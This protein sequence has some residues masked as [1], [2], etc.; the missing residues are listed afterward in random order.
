MSENLSPGQRVARFAHRARWRLLLTFSPE[1]HRVY[2]SEEARE[3]ALSKNG[4]ASP[5][6][7]ITTPGPG[8]E[9]IY[10]V[11]VEGKTY[12]MPKFVPDS[13]LIPIYGEI[14]DP[15]HPHY[16]EYKEC[17]ISPGDVV[18][19]AGASEGFFTRFA[20][21]KGANVII[22]EP[23]QVWIDALHQTFAPEIAA[24]RIHIE[25]ACLE[26]HVG[27]AEMNIDPEIG[28][29][30]DDQPGK[31]ELIPLLTLDAL[32]A[33]SK[34]GRCDFIKMDIEGAERRAIAGAQETLRKYKPN[35]SIAVYHDPSGYLDIRSDLNR[36]HP[37]YQVTAKGL[38]Q[39]YRYKIP[40]M[41]HAWAS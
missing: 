40:V 8:S 34:W 1:M 17:R 22:V 29:V 38:L 24:G 15:T 37:E 4:H 33:K 3:L 25:R 23:S 6:P 39:R 9:A 26:D 21:D 13:Q 35:L 20:L 18:I 36:L 19:D 16:Y 2:K 28:W 32:V 41:L 30:L 10:P 27:E 12:Y 31:L 7:K 5:P 14:F 11:D